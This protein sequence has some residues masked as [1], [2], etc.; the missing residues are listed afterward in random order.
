MPPKKNAKSA[1]SASKAAG[2]NDGTKVKNE[3]PAAS[4]EKQEPEQE[5]SD[6]KDESAPSKDTSKAKRPPHPTGTPNKRVAP[7]SSSSET[8]SKA[9]RRSARSQP[10]P[11]HTHQQTLSFL[12][13]P[14]ARDLARPKDEQSLPAST[15]TYTSTVPMTPFEELVCAVVL[16]R[17]ISHA[18][19]QRTIR[20][21][22]NSPYNLTTPGRIKEIGEQKLHEALWEAKTQHKQK[23]V[24]Q[25][26]GLADVVLER[27][28]NGE[29]DTSLEKLRKESEHDADVLAETVRNSIKG[30]GVTAVNIFQRRAQGLWEECY[31]FV[32]DR[33][34]RGLEGF[35]MP[36]DA[37]ELKGVLEKEW[38]GLKGKESLQG[39][40]EEEKKRMAF[41]VILERATGLDL[42]G[43]VEEALEKVGG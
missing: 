36:G 42:E 24:E 22:F 7:P 39:K 9:P 6:E 18:L 40:N 30:I 15:K 14:T 28:A 37:E 3:A 10:K 33:T 21:I 2:S 32:D 34:R 29:K 12:L 31:P 20:T 38:K 27:F 8:P 16:S 5:T 41:V 35:G 4:D 23:T 19:G 43:K 17:P 25:L 13:S 1:K 26:L 11:N